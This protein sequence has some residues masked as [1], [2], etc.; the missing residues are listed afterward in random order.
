MTGHTLGS[1]WGIAVR[2]HRPSGKLN[3]IYLRCQMAPLGQMRCCSSR[4]SA[5]CRGTFLHEV[6]AQR[7][8]MIRE[9]NTVYVLGLQGMYNEAKDR[10][11]IRRDRHL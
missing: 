9:Q 2:A 5:L 8:P 1:K 4:L 7:L 11:N 10:I 6:T 3:I